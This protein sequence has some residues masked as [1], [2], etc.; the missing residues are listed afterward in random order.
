MSA[1]QDPDVE[2]S[3]PFLN[4]PKGCRVVRGRRIVVVRSIRRWQ[5]FVPMS[6]FT[7]FNPWDLLFGLL[8]TVIRKIVPRFSPGWQCG[9][10]YQPNAEMTRKHQ[11][12]EKRFF[13]TEEE[14]DAFHAELMERV[15][16]G[17]FDA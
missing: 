9:V 12:L 11:V 7:G 13:E 3:A 1:D 16:A 8:Y 14:A 15:R 10:F 17:D 5:S 2:L 6:A 4:F